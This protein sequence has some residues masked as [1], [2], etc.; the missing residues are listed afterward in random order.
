V[1][2][3]YRKSLSRLSFS[4][5]SES[6]I[7]RADSAASERIRLKLVEKRATAALHRSASGNKSDRRSQPHR[8]HRA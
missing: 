2:D 5:S 6:R 4:P 7:A 8:Q 3:K 1:G